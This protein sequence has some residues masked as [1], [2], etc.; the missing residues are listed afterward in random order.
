[1][2]RAVMGHA[3]EGL[4]KS[5]GDRSIEILRT[6]YGLSGPYLTLKTPALLNPAQPRY[7]RYIFPIT[8]SIPMVYPTVIVIDAVALQARAE[9]ERAGSGDPEKQS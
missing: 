2:G 3:C 1:M 4:T 7:Y 9:F 8:G 5:D 6:L